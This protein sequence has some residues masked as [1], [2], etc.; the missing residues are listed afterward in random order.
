MTSMT[1]NTCAVQI[2]MREIHFLSGGSFRARSAFSG[3][4]CCVLAVLEMEAYHVLELIGEGSFGKVYKGRLKSS[5]QA[6][7]RSEPLPLAS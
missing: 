7:R 1:L 3:L 5:K 2:V 4:Y 6:S